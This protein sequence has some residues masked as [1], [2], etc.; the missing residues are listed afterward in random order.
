MSFWD[1]VRGPASVRLLVAFGES[2]GLTA[3]RLLQRSGLTLRQLDDPQAELTAAQELQ[4]VGN[5][6]RLLKHPPGLGLE[7]GTRY[8]FSTYG[9]WGYGLVSSATAADALALALRFI[10]LTF[11][12]SLIAARQEGAQCIL[13]FEEPEIIDMQARRFLVE[14]DMAAAARLMKD[15]VGPDFRLSHFTLKGPARARRAL[16][17]GALDLGGVPI[18]Y[19]AA[20]N[21]LAF[22]TSFL[23]RPLPQSNPVTVSMCE[24]MCREL[25]ARRRVRLGT[26]EL[27]RQYL[28][29]MPDG[30]APGLP[31]VALMVK[32]SQRTLKRRLQEEGTTFTRILS[33]YRS[34]RARELIADRSLS[35]TEIAE[36]LGFSDLS[37]FSQAFKRWFGVAPSAHR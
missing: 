15:V 1:F 27:V 28:A 13:S 36:R 9:L 3:S 14:R 29:A 22:H 26:A 32:L 5:L 17:A 37:S 2:R 12:F 8:N 30:V 31:Q 21:S 24:R 6:L 34:S 33:E 18:E 16:G 23:T 7:V 19:G 25:L 10:P 11:A 4:V 35:L 20:S